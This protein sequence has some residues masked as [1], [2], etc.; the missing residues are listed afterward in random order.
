M[1]NAKIKQA[2]DAFLLA[3]TNSTK[4]FVKYTVGN[5]VL[6]NEI[7]PDTFR[8]TSD[9]NVFIAG[10]IGAEDDGRN[11]IESDKFSFVSDADINSGIPLKGRVVYNAD[12]F[13]CISTG[14]VN[15]GGDLIVK[16]GSGLKTLKVYTQ[17]DIIQQD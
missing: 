4:V 10:A 8:V 16:T 13:S 1:T 3:K 9:N 2:L 11:Y 5:K 14:E 7:K 12:G 15:A 6:S 17:S